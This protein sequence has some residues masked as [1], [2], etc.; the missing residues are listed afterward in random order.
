MS[1]QSAI[2]VMAG[3]MILI[4]LAL[5]HWLSPWWLLWTAFVGFNLFQSG[6]TGFCP[7]NTIFSKFGL[8][9]AGCARPPAQRQ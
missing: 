5:A 7:A 6:I 1:R 9:D 4:S 8:K 3:S 2:Q